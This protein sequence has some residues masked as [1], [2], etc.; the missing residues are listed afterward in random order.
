M[1]QGR[2]ADVI[3]N[4]ILV[5]LVPFIAPAYMHM[6]FLALII[7]HVYLYC[8]DQVKVLRYVVSFEISSS[9]V[10]TLGMKLFSIPLSVLAGALVFKGN[11]LTGG[12]DLG[13][14]FLKDNTLLVAIVGAMSLHVLLHLALLRC[15][16]SGF[17]ADVDRSESPATYENTAKSFPAT[18]FSVN[19]VHCLRSKYGIN[20]KEEEQFYSPFRQPA[21]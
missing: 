20:Q 17:S 5:T 14:G 13:G 21:K 15:V 7:S 9:D 2:Y 8:Y 18:Y 12:Q 10:H 3:F 4:V 11:Q 16:V 6:T 19:P 1:E